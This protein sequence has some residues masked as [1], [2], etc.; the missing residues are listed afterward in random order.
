MSMNKQDSISSL[1]EGYYKR[2]ANSNVMVLAEL[3]R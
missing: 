3:F 1:V 2:N